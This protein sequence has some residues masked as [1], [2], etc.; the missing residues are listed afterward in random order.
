MPDQGE[1]TGSPL[2]ARYPT[3]GTFASFPSLFRSSMRILVHDFAGHPFQVQ[4]SRAFARRGHTVLHAYC[5]S[6]PST[7]QAMETRPDDPDGF[8]IR[9]LALDSPINKQAFVQR[10]RQERAYGHLAAG[11]LRDFR[12]DVMLS[13]NTPLDAQRTLLEAAR[14]VGARFVYWVQDLIGWASERLLREKVPV[15]GGFVGGYYA[16]LERRLLA[17]SD[18]LVLV[19]EDFRGAV[20]EIRD[21]ASAHVIPIWSPLDA[22]SPRPRDNAWA[23][24]QGF[25]EKALRF[26]YAGTLG[27]KHNP[28]LLLDLAHRIPHEIVVVSQGAGTDWLRQ[29]KGIENVKNLRLLPFQPFEALPEVLGAA[30]VLVA[31]LTPDA[32]VFSVPS[33]VLTYLCAARPLLLAVPPQNLAARIVTEHEAGLVVPPRKRKDFLEAGARLAADAALRERLGANARAYAEAHF[34]IEPITDRFEAVLAEDRA[35]VRR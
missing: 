12:P 19:T 11:A 14:E 29:K 35:T 33:K 13:A 18:A 20:P 1:H 34:A 21:H 23:E 16:R 25:P 6:L 15:L 2:R 10:W 7:P 4:L 9:G 17:E 8:E 31:I 5:A 26:V 28:Q 32:G 22:V 24:A 27:L 3:V 30:D